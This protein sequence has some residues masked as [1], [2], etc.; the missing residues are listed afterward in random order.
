[1]RANW[2]KILF[3]AIP[4]IASFASMTVTATIHL[5]IVGQLGALAIAV[6]GVSNIIMYNAWALFSGIGHTVNYLVAQNFGANQLNKGIERTYL[7]LY[8]CMAA[9]V[10]VILCGA[11]LTDGI[12]LLMSGSEELVR[13]GGDYL[14]VRF[15]AMVFSIFSFVFHGFFRGIGDT[16]TPMRLSIIGNLCMIFF[17]YTLTHGNWGFPKLG[18]AGA[19]WALLIGEVVGALGCLYVYFVRLHP[20]LPDTDKGTF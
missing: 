10:F 17:T 2:N 13:A 7:A 1:M 20:P 9:S 11:L 6:V 5:M 18:L 4:S 15:F 3:L 19:G 16:R 12:L 14:R 8:L